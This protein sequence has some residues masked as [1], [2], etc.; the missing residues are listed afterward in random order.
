[1]FFFFSCTCKWNIKKVADVLQGIQMKLEFDEECVLVRIMSE[2]D[3]SIDLC[4]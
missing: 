4:Y 3:I 2:L 1:M